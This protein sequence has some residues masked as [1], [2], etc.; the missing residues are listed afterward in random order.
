MLD[1][2][3]IDFPLHLGPY[4]ME[5]LECW[6]STSAGRAGVGMK[7]KMDNNWL[8]EQGN[9]QHSRLQD[10]APIS[11]GHALT[12]N[13]PNKQTDANNYL[14]VCVCLQGKLTTSNGNPTLCVAARRRRRRRRCRRR[15][16]Q[17]AVALALL[18]STH[19][20]QCVL[21]G[22]RHHSSMFSAYFWWDSRFL[23]TFLWKRFLISFLNES[24]TSKD[25]NDIDKQ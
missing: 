6:R 24:M 22:V 9:R 8:T 7:K 12:G 13:T 25:E 19:S 20:K 18:F 11:I 4:K 14:N 2:V 5:G 15:W 3:W 21:L 17:E 16:T 1:K 23:Q 10:G